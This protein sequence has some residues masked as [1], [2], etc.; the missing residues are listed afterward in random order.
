M[1]NFK[2][3]LPTSTQIKN[4]LENVLPYGLPTALA[5]VECVEEEV[6]SA[7]SC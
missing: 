2:L 1:T 6:E 5:V 7:D 3:H 4:I